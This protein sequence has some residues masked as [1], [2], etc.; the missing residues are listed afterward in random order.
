[1]LTR[2]PLPFIGGDTQSQPLAHS[3]GTAPEPNAH[4]MGG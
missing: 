4:A 1:M 3:S 2:A